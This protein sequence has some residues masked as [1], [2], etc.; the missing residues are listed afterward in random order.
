MVVDDSDKPKEMEDC[1]IE[2]IELFI[3]QLIKKTNKKIDNDN[4]FIQGS[5]HFCFDNIDDNN[6]KILKWYI[7]CIKKEKNTI[8]SSVIISIN[9]KRENITKLC[10]YTCIWNYKWIS[11]FIKL[12]FKIQNE[13]LMIWVWHAD[14][15]TNVELR[16]S[17]KLTSNK[18][19]KCL[20]KDIKLDHDFY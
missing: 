10:I 15:G 7:S 6:Y 13:L 17:H 16:S 3:V 4:I 2:K 5:I 9:I 18:L 19:Y 14:Q 1:Y 8:T 20:K 12:K 11:L